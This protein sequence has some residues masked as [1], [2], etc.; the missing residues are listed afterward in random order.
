MSNNKYTFQSVS[1]DGR[2]DY[3]WLYYKSPENGGLFLGFD[4]ETEPN[5]VL[6]DDFPL[7]EALDHV[8][9]TRKK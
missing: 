5:W 1:K 9:N 8:N 4:L 7:K 2:R 3:W 6:P